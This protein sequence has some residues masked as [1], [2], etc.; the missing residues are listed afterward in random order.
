[1]RASDLAAPFP[2]VEFS[3]TGLEA[4]RLLAGQDLPGL[5]V[6]D[7]DGRPSTILA[8]TDAETLLGAITLDALMDRLVA[9]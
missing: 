1:M 4:A 2:T 6:I 8:A 3:T 5:I 7:Q 9:T